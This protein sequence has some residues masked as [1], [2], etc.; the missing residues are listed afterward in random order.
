MDDDVAQ[1]VSPEMQ[2]MAAKSLEPFFAEVDGDYA[3]ML[4]PIA[5]IFEA[6][7]PGPDD[8]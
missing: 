6:K 7:G 3:D 1:E 8:E 2:A 4:E 5:K